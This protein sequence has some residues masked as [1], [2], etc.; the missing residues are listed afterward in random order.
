M[1]NVTKIDDAR[2][3][4][5][6]GLPLNA[7][8]KDGGHVEI[9]V[10]KQK[11]MGRILDAGTECMKR[12]YAFYKKQTPHRYS[13]L[14]Q[15]HARL[16]REIAKLPQESDDIADLLIYAIIQP[17]CIVP[18]MFWAD[19]FQRL[20]N[21]EEV[22]IQAQDVWPVGDPVVRMDGK[23]PCLFESSILE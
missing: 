16:S 10:A 6:M 4:L 18:A 17:R 7:Q 1:S 12:A 13:A 5:H 3:A 9:P 14:K 15:A 22:V 11:R 23:P 8:F 21:G 19:V 20:A 2:A